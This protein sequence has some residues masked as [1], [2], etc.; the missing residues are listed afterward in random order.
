[1]MR[2]WAFIGV[3]AMGLMML[4]MHLGVT[5]ALYYATGETEID[6]TDADRLAQQVAEA[7][8]SEDIRDQLKEAWE[9][10]MEELVEELKLRMEQLGRELQDAFEGGMSPATKPSANKSVGRRDQEQPARAP[11]GLRPEDQEAL[12]TLLKKATRGEA[13]S[14]LEWHPSERATTCIARKR[15]AVEEVGEPVVLDLGSAR[16]SRHVSSTMGKLPLV[17]AKRVY[18]WSPW[19]VAY[20]VGGCVLIGFATGAFCVAVSRQRA[21]SAS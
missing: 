18:S 12:R 8:S 9:P 19:L 17:T 14:E 20:L 2:N 11:Y 10:A 1:M 15:L 3:L 21:A 16:A 6:V 5:A 13:L 4:G 7:L